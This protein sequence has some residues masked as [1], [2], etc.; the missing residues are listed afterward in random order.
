ME[1]ISNLSLIIDDNV[2]LYEIILV[3]N[4]QYLS[5]VSH[6]KFFS[7]KQKI[8]YQLQNN[9]LCLSTLYSLYSFSVCVRSPCFLFSSM[10]K[11]SNCTKYFCTIQCIS[12]NS[13]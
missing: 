5:E 6:R 12:S 7:E 11:N 13:K 3:I 1:S 10:M 2:V 4:F 9:R 8:K